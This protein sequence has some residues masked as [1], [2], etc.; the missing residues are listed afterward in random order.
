MNDTF[1]R[2]QYKEIARIINQI[3]NKT[4]QR[5]IT[6]H[7]AAELKKN[8]NFNEDKFLKACQTEGVS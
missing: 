2:K 6:W 4:T 8:L 5:E 1:S 3:Y 7:F